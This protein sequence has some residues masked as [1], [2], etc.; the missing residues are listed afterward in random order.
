METLISLITKT[1]RQCHEVY[2]NAKWTHSS[3]HRSWRRIGGKIVDRFLVN[4]DKVV[5]LDRS[6]PSLKALEAGCDAA[7]RLTTVTADMTDPS[8]VAAFAAQMQEVH[9][10]VDVLVNCAGYYPL[11]PFE[12][13][14]LAQWQEILANNLTGSFQMVR[15]LLPLLKE[16]GWGRIVNR[17]GFD[18]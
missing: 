11:V 8:E 16:S 14:T 12:Q 1:F 9:G 17:L 6:E 5:G 13:M 7:T 10:R 2:E 4:G 3:D 18:L 15:A